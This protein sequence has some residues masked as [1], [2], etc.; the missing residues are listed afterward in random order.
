MEKKTQDAILKTGTTLAAVVIAGANVRYAATHRTFD[1][2]L[3]VW[4]WCALS[5]F[6]VLFLLLADERLSLKKVLTRS[7]FNIVAYAVSFLAATIVLYSVVIVFYDGAMI[8]RKLDS[9]YQSAVAALLA[10]IV[11]FG[12]R[13]W[14]R[15]WYGAAEV[16]VGVVV[17]YL[18]YEANVGKPT[19]NIFFAVLTAGVY[20]VVRGLDNVHQGWATDRSISAIRRYLGRE[21]TKVQVD[22]LNKVLDDKST[23]KEIKDFVEQMIDDRLA[24]LNAG[25]FTLSNMFDHKPGALTTTADQTSFSIAS[26]DVPAEANYELPPLDLEMYAPRD[27][28]RKAYS[29]VFDAA[30]PMGSRAG[31]K[32]KLTLDEQWEQLGQLHHEFNQGESSTHERPTATLERLL[33]EYG[34]SATTEAQRA[35]AE[36]PTEQFRRLLRERME[37]KAR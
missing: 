33:K 5:L 10:G 8:V 2:A 7:V 25:A 26:D 31:R 6:A 9:A 15:F 17:A 14:F 24:T 1:E 22:D 3:Y 12:I 19:T 32:P 28:A 11:F 30:K 4:L 23:P 13:L 21:A 36:T 34:K 37:R 29:G 16:V 27:T 35:A 20:L 18:S